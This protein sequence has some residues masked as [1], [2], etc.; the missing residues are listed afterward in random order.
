MAMLSSSS[1]DLTFGRVA[2]DQGPGLFLFCCDRLFFLDVI[3]LSAH[4]DHDVGLSSR[5]DV[6]TRP[7]GAVGREF[8]SLLHRGELEQQAGGVS[9]AFLACHGAL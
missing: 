1:S 8:F 6:D 4:R 9:F 2:S 3:G 5:V 7:V